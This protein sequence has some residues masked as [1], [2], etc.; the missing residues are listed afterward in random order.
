MIES[1]CLVPPEAAKDHKTVLV[2]MPVVLT[3][4]PELP[5]ST[6]RRNEKAHF[7][8]VNPMHL[9][10]SLKAVI[11]I[12]ASD[13]YL[14]CKALPHVDIDKQQ[15]NWEE[16]SKNEFNPGQKSAVDFAKAIANDKIDDSCDPFLTAN[17]MNPK[18]RA[19]VLRAL[20]IHW[21]LVKPYIGEP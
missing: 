11:T 12:M 9:S 21:G 14:V 4:A 7:R 10:W 17:Q 5:A 1:S 16:I 18:L 20:E 2:L 19:A 13:P 3:A 6:E 8:V 15:I